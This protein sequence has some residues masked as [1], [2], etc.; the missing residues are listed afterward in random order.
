[1]QNS[2]GTFLRIWG[3]FE[4]NFGHFL[5]VVENPGVLLLEDLCIFAENRQLGLGGALCAGHARLI[6]DEQITMYIT[7]TKQP[8][9]MHHDQVQLHKTSEGFPASQVL[10]Q[11][12]KDAVCRPL[13]LSRW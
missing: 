2:L 12:L 11:L 1:M 5:D 4:V 3:H 7:I 10:H 9:S 8:F 6:S 13:V